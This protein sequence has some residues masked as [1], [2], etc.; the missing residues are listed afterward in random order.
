LGGFLSAF[1]LA[2]LNVHVKNRRTPPPFFPVRLKR[3]QQVVL[4]AQGKSLALAVMVIKSDGNVR[5]A[6]VWAYHDLRLTMRDP[7]ARGLIIC[8]GTNFC[9]GARRFGI[10]P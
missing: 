5:E 6:D 2:F 1:F 8:L 3:P 10:Q 4:L 9:A 7:D